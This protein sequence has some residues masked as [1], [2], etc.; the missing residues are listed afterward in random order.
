MKI[1]AVGTELLHADER[2]DR[3]DEVA[4]SCTQI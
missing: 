2:T 3:D 1:R 4:L